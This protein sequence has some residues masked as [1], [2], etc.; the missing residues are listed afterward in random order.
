MLHTGHHLC[1]LRRK[2]VL[3]YLCLRLSAGRYQKVHLNGGVNSLLYG[4]S[5]LIHIS[6]KYSFEAHDIK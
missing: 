2:V 4:L 5:N 3:V 1:P 6:V